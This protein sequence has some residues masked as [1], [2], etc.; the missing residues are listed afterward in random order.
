MSNTLAID[1]ISTLLRDVLAQATGQTEL[2]SLDINGLL[3]IGQKTLLT[4]AEPVMNAISQVISR[5]IISERPYAARFAAMQRDET[6]WGNIVRKIVFVEDPNDLEDNPYVPLVDGQSVDQ[7]AVRKPKAVQLNF[8]GQQSYEVAKTFFMRQ[9][10][11]AFNS[12][13]EFGAFISGVYT[14]VFNK[15]EKIHE[16]TARATLC[17][18]VAGKIA[19]DSSNVV[20]ALS[21]YNAETGQDLDATTVMAPENYSNFWKWLHGRMESISDLMT[22]YSCKFHTN[23]EDGVIERHTPKDL[24]KVYIYAP[25]LHQTT[26]RVLADSYHDTFLKLPGAQAV[27]FWQNIDEPDSIKVK[28]PNYLAPDGSIKKASD[29]VSQSKV[30]AVICDV[31]ACGYSPILTRTLTTPL[32]AKGEYY[33]VYWKF[34]ERHWIDFTENAVVILLD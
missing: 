21:E 16:E 5:T 6:E 7:Y 19:G 22:E 23:L 25:I 24:Q 31:E 32:N 17:G 28:T 18:L 1:Q 8:Y 26:S 29:D 11:T 34:N 14:Y 3:T 2:N 12:P 10:D 4:G 33:C 30:F 9:L 20:H 27:N 15:I 13:E